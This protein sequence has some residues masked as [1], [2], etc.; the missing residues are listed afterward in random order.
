MHEHARALATHAPPEARSRRLTEGNRSFPLPVEP[1]GRCALL[2]LPVALARAEI[3]AR[4]LADDAH[5]PL[6]GA[7]LSAP[8]TRPP[9]HD[10]E[11]ELLHDVGRVEAEVAHRVLRGGEQLARQGDGDRAEGASIAVAGSLDQLVELIVDVGDGANGG[12]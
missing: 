10:G 4:H 9:F 12:G 1:P 2:D 6:A 7:L 11:E 5:Q 8:E 3:L